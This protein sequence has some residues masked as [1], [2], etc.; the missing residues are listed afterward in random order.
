MFPFLAINKLIF[1]NLCFLHGHVQC[2]QVEQISQCHSLKKRPKTCSSHD[3]LVCLKEKAIP[4]SKLNQQ[5]KVEQR[6]VFDTLGSYEQ[7]REQFLKDRRKEYLEYLKEV[8]SFSV[9][10]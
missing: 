10:D 2:N 4:T 3:S 6:H 7:K 1:I 9:S 5:P 8:R